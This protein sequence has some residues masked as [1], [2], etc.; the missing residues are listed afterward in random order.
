MPNNLRNT[1]CMIFYLWGI[2]LA[3]LLSSSKVTMLKLSFVVGLLSAISITRAGEI[4][5][6]TF[7]CPTFCLT[8]ERWGKKDGRKSKHGGIERKAY[9]LHTHIKRTRSLWG[10]D[11]YVLASLTFSFVPSAPKIEIIKPL[12][13]AVRTYFTVF[14]VPIV[15]RNWVI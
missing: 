11:F 2:I 5:F 15:L 12:A 14:L 3:P 4:F 9:E 13:R 10:P 7:C 8:L 6:S 1:I